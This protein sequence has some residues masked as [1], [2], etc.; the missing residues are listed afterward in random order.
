[1]FTILSS[2]KIPAFQRP[3]DYIVVHCT[4]TSMLTNVSSL[5]NYW[6]ECLG[7]KSPGYHFV[8]NHKGE[9]IQLAEEVQM[10]NGV[11]GFNKTSIHIA[12]VG[13]RGVDGSYYDT[14][15]DSQRDAMVSLISSLLMTYPNAEVL[16]H[17]DL[18]PDLDGDGIVEE[19]EWIKEC[20]LF[21]A[22]FEYAKIV[23]HAKR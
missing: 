8:I 18:S 5:V 9:L 11:R 21:D 3:I 22:Q 6:R 20:P 13:G 23:E 1:M 17:R 10:V 15:T 14:R 4:A 19:H 16:G 2:R 7:W 12:Y